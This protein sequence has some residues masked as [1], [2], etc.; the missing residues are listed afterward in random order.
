MVRTASSVTSTLRSVLWPGRHCNIAVIEPEWPPLRGGASGSTREAMR[1]HCLQV[2]H[3]DAVRFTLHRI[4]EVSVL[5]HERVSLR[6]AHKPA[7][8]DIDHELEFAHFDGH[9]VTE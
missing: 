6:A 9:A 1:S 2:R 4:N 3:A 7:L 8:T 5:A